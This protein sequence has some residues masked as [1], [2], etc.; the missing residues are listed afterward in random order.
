VAKQTY[1]MMAV[2]TK[3]GSGRG[4][5]GVGVSDSAERRLSLRFHLMQPL[6]I[7]AFEYELLFK[8]RLLLKVI[9][10]PLAVDVLLCATTE[11]A[12]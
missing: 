3:L 11:T 1:A 2:S 9:A 12:I 7:S 6:L 10:I 5:E 8:E 4:G